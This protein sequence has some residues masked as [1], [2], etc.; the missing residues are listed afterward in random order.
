MVCGGGGGRGYH[1]S[2]RNNV[3]VEQAG[4]RCFVEKEAERQTAEAD[5]AGVSDIPLTPLRAATS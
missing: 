1:C 4:D 3:A 2:S 5:R